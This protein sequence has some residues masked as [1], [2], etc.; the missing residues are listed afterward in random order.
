MEDVAAGHGQRRLDVQRRRRLQ[1]RAAVRVPGQAVGQWLG[2]VLVELGGHPAHRLLADPVG[3]VQLRRGV[4][5]EQGERVQP[6]SP[7]ID[8]SVSEW[9]YTSKG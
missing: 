5:A 2:Q 3:G 8:G 4:Q 1:A 6:A 7:T 9:Q